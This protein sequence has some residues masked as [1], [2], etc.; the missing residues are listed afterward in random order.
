MPNYIAPYEE[1]FCIICGADSWRYVACTTCR[2][3]ALADEETIYQKYMRKSKEV[4]A[5]KEQKGEK[6]I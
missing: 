5:R 6:G 3:E 4:Q 2:E 1:N